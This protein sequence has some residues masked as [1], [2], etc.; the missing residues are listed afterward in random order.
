MEAQ[1]RNEPSTLCNGNKKHLWKLAGAL[2]FQSLFF[3]P[4]NPAKGNFSDELAHK[5]CTSLPTAHLT[6]SEPVFLQTLWKYLP[7]FY[8]QEKVWYCVS[9]TALQRK[10][11]VT[12]KLPVY[13]SNLFSTGMLLLN[14][15]TLLIVSLSHEPV[16][17]GGNVSSL[18][19]PYTWCVSCPDIYNDHPG[20]L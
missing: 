16:G 10:T 11:T 14:I 6:K 15:F 2:P 4:I 12:A 17:V 5:G 8:L 9:T 20:Q 1:L 18:S 3:S 19:H 13:W 7:C